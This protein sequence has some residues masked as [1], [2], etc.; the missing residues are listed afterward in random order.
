MPFTPQSTL[1]SAPAPGSIYFGYGSNMWLDQ[2]RR[3]CPHSTYLGIARLNGYRWLINSRHYANVALSP[4]P[5]KK[6]DAGGVVWGLVYHLTPADEAAL[7]VNEGVPIAYEKAW[8]PCDFWASLP[9]PPSPSSDSKYPSHLDASP[10]LP[11][12]SNA[13]APPLSNTP[14]LVYINHTD[15][16]DS[17][18]AAEYIVRMNHAI[19]DGLAMGVPTDYVDGVMRRYIP[20]ENPADEETGRLA[21]KNSMAFVDPD[22]A[23]RRVQEAG[24]ARRV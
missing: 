2:M 21:V 19:R 7:D 17:D 10:P 6:D 22:E 13:T 18:P 1:A 5:V 9:P 12:S 3:R 4:P 16:T 14:M 20:A 23:V 24:A 8:L 15:A 11:R